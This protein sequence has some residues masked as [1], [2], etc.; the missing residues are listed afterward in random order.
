MIEGPDRDPC[1]DWGTYRK[2]FHDTSFIQTYSHYVEK[3]LQPA[4]GCAARF[5]GQMFFAAGWV[6]FGWH[7]SI[8]TYIYTF[9]ILYICIYGY[10]RMYIY[11]CVC[12]Y[13]CVHVYLLK[14]DWIC[15]HVYKIIYIYI[16]VC[17]IICLF[18]HMLLYIFNY[19][20]IHM[21]IFKNA[22]YTYPFRC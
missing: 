19:I 8:F 4:S 5:I 10:L 14:C 15:I 13:V 12:M 16:Y 6:N 20:Y 1:Q 2:Y 9:I 17:V 3:V 22:C 21:H 11:M 18:V 7:T